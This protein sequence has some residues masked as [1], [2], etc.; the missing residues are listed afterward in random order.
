MCVS[1]GSQHIIH[2]VSG[3]ELRVWVEWDLSSI[4]NDINIERLFQISSLKPLILSSSLA[5]LMD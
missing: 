1:Y 5:C 4:K 3:S 2:N